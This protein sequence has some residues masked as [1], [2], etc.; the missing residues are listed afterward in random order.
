M[1]MISVVV[2]DDHP[3]VRTGLTTVI[4]S[5]KDMKVV[6]E[7][8]HGKEAIELFRAH[9][10]DVLMID[11][12]MPVMNGLD[13][14]VAIRG[15][16]PDSRILVLTSFEAE[17][18]AVRILAAGAMGFLSKDAVGEEMLQAIRAVR[19]GH[20]RVSAGMG[21][22]LADRMTRSPLSCRELELL[23]C[24]ARG[25]TNK[26]LAAALGITEGTV[27]G[28]VNSILSKLAV[29]DRTMAVTTALQKGIIR[30]D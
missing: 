18:D 17:E 21:A 9:Q 12:R 16:F 26:E 2:V 22:Q 25:G 4:N 7:G 29:T 10:P 27:K 5:Q 24:M 20:R 14:T 30:L 13:A 19:S 1:S 28:H 8:R 6:A 15:E 11:L 23:R 3:V